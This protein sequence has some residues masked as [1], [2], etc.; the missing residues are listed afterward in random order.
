MER[1]RPRDYSSTCNH[2]ETCG[3]RT[4]LHSCTAREC[5]LAARNTNTT[6]V[7]TERGRQARKAAIDGDGRSAL[8]TRRAA[9]VRISTPVRTSIHHQYSPPFGINHQPHSNP[10]HGNPHSGPLGIVCRLLRPPN[11]PTFLHYTPPY[12]SLRAK[13]AAVVGPPGLRPILLSLQP[14]GFRLP[15]H[16]AHLLER[17]QVPPLLFHRCSTPGSK[18]AARPARPQRQEMAPSYPRICRRQDAGYARRESQRKGQ[19]TPEEDE[20]CGRHPGYWRCG[21]VS[22]CPALFET[23]F[24]DQEQQPPPS[25]STR[26]LQP[27][28]RPSVHV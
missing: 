4:Q 5:F 20:V 14:R 8:S 24:E 21:S 11:F 17:S 22:L 2:P 28:P 25:S 1:A 27:F 7:V 19:S 13:S 12:C 3:G 9:A 10:V 6:A 26:L 23:P 16:A 18:Y 15:L